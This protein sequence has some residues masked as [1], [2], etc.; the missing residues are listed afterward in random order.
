MERVL[1][2]E[3]EKVCVVREEMLRVSRKDESKRRKI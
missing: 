3:K 2:K 1:G